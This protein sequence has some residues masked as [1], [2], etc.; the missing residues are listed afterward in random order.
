MNKIVVVSDWHIGWKRAGYD[1]IR[2]ALDLIEENYK[3]I[4]IL[5]LNG[6]IFDLWRCSYKKTRSTPIYNDIFERLQRIT[7][8]IRTVYIRGNHDY[9]AD[10]IIGDDLNVE[11]T[12]MFVN[13]N[14]CYIHEDRFSTLQI[15][16]FSALITKRFHFISKFVDRTCIRPNISANFVK[17]IEKFKT[18]NFFEHVIVAHNHISWIYK[19]IVFCG[20]SVHYPSYIEVTDEKIKIKKI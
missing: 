11:Y 4:D 15:E 6:D 9:G 3:E 13:N 1:S 10:K 5:I 20:D 18:D 16:S 14:I 7:N 8:T 12:R 17:R 2:R 19:G